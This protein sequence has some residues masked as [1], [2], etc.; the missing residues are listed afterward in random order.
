MVKIFT[1]LSEIT[2][3]CSLY[4]FTNIKYCKKSQIWCS[5]NSVWMWS[6]KNKLNKIEFHGRISLHVFRRGFFLHLFEKYRICCKIVVKV[7]GK[8]SIT[9]RNL[10]WDFSHIRPYC[11]RISWGAASI[12]CKFVVKW[13][14]IAGLFYYR[15]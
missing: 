5:K 7:G 3:N 14:H 10:S 4:G 8:V 9:V 6:K 13:R 1:F 2:W 12:C 11:S 15:R